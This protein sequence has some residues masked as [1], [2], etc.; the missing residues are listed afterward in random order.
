VIGVAPPGFDY[1]S[2]TAVWTP[3]V[4]DTRKIP[5]TGVTFWDTVARLKPGL[6]FARAKRMF[7]AEAGP[8][9]PPGNKASGGYHAIE[10]ELIPLR[11]RL[12]GSIRE[13]SLVLMGV[14]AFVL[15]IAC[16]NVAHLLLSRVAERRPELAI[17]AALGA[18]R[19]RLVQQLI[20]ESTLLTIV[21]AAAGLGIARWASRLASLAQ[22]AQLAAQDYSVLDWRV[23]AFAV[24]LAAATGLLFGVLPAFLT[25]RMQPLGDPVRSQAGTRQSGANRMRSILLAIQATCTLVLLAGSLLMG[26]TFLR[27]VGT[28]LGFRTNGVFTLSV[29]LSGSRYQ[30][31]DTEADYYRQALERLRAVPGVESAGAVPFLPLVDQPYMGQELSLDAA[32]KVPVTATMAATPDYFRTIGTE[33]LDG[34]EFTVADRANSERV[35]IVNEEFVRGLGAGS[36]VVGQRLRNWTGK[37]QYTVVGVTRNQRM[38]GP[39]GKETPQAYFP[40]EQF[41]LDFITFVARVRGNAQEYLAVCR[42]AVRLVDPQVAVYDVKTLDQRLADNLARPRFYTTVILF[43][44][45]F[46]LLLAV[47]G[48]YGVASYA[49]WQ[50]THEIGVRMAIGAAPLNLR[51][52]LLRESMLPLWLGLAAGVAGS[53]ALGSFLQNLVATAPP[54]DPFTCAAASLVLSAAAATAVWIA[55]RR[56]V[57]INPTNALRAE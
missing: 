11:D 16:A 28:D 37:Q 5:R 36:R 41:S 13:A 2:R 21:A 20:T 22:P 14:A 43:F 35:V 42:D 40:I 49:V 32:H 34:R 55:T 51:L 1:P 52:M 39:A 33:I 24:G 15:L 3:T 56:V 27:L 26:R 38:R 9:K 57:R 19:V 50:R 48:L 7:E 10:P 46:A 8:R 25:G 31:N 4:F 30:A 29:S 44:G 53:Y 54:I 12:A 18:S 17:R 45:G 23:L 6:A 47:I